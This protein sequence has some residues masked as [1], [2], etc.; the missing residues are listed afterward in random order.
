MPLIL[1]NRENPAYQD[2][3][4]CKEVMKKSPEILNLVFK[5]IKNPSYPELYNEFHRTYPYLSS[6]ERTKVEIVYSV[7]NGSGNFRLLDVTTLPQKDRRALGRF[8]LKI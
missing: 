2:F 4:R 8:L 3:L 6:G 5:D 7:W 1:K